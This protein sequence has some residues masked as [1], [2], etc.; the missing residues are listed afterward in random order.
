MLRTIHL[1]GALGEAFGREHRLCVQ[2]A[3]E[4]VRAL[5]I[6]FAGFRRAF[7]P[8]KYHVVRGTLDRPHGL[9][10]ET[11]DMRLGSA[12]LH[13][14]PV[15]EGAGGGRGGAV[16]K[17]LVGVAMVAGAFFFAPAGAGLFGANL[18]A[19]AFS[20]AGVGVTYGNIAAIGLAVALSGV[21]QLLAPQPKL[22]A[23]TERDR[24]ESFLFNGAS[25]TAQ[26]GG[27]VPVVYGRALVGSMVISAGLQAEQI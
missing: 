4:A 8:G 2:S 19:T 11:I 21:S 17:I 18:G 23:G 7:E 15:V 9:D 25:N 24:R 1:H 13:I 14:V 5:S 26:Q 20:V 22:N 10:P 27:A 12:D 3:R 16:A 6:L